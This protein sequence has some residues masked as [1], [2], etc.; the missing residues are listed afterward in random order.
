MSRTRR[1]GI[2]AVFGYVQFG[3][4]LVTGF[5]LVPFVLS[6][7][8]TDLYGVWLAFGEVLAYSSMVDLGV[9]GV[10]PW[11]V[12]EA[13]GRGDR[14]AMRE[15]LGASLAF[16]G[17]ASVVFLLLACGALALAPS[18][19]T[20]GAAQHAAVVG[21]ILLL[22]GGM[23]V[24]M[25]LRTFY[26]AEVGLQDV[27]FVGTL[28]L[29]QMAVGIAIT[30]GMLL[31][32]AG[33]YALAT[34]VVVPQLISVAA[35]WLRLRAREPD[36]LRGWSRPRWAAVRAT[37]AQGFGS[38]TASLGW[39]MV[40]ASDSMVILALLGP[41]AAVVYAMTAK[42]GTTAMQMSWQ[43]PD[44]G[45]VGLAQLK[46]EGRPDRVREV[47]L[48]LVRLTLVAS[49]G[50]AVVV[51]ALNPAFVTLWVGAERFGGVRLNAVLAAVVLAHSLTHALF[52][53]AG[54]LGA[55]VQAGWAALVQ[56]AA[57]L[58][59]A[60]LL[61]RVLGLAGVA[62]AAVI[63]TVVVAY[64][65]GAALTR[66][67]TGLG[68]AELWRG[69]LRSWSLRMAALLPLAGAV[70]V[71]GVRVSPWAAVGAGPLL[72]LFYLWLMR[73][74]YEGLPLPSRARRLLV[75]VRLLPAA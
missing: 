5:A 24:T 74:L 16:S 21:P 61:G 64:P 57:N 73:P 62:L 56:G 34:A 32:G 36:L 65:A 27:A 35:C 17:G 51:V 54:V 6:R 53:T 40:S 41:A 33:L 12:A 71:A 58:A 7:V 3:L 25:P 28:A 29:S 75:A 31:A 68:H 10:V 23:A 39:R 69:A 70:G 66:R 49:G 48:S 19:A 18:L 14:A 43:L 46:G 44:A 8:P 60:L 37:A 11:L 52:T 59:C 67:T 15:V 2:A 38:W 42:L 63:S 30:V 22:V 26:A 20:L 9:V 13:H 47:V 45:L 50:V 55:R 72:G 1:A 4:S